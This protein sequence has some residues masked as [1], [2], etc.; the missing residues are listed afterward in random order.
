MKS[1]AAASDVA[2]A[3][4]FILVLQEILLSGNVFLYF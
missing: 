4:L 1:Q 2:A 3:F